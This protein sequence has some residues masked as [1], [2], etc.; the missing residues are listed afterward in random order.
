MPPPRPV[1]EPAAVVSSRSTG[2]NAGV[3]T[4]AQ[5][6]MTSAVD[7]LSTLKHR[8]RLSRRFDNEIRIEVMKPVSRLDRAEQSHARR[9]IGGNWR[10]RLVD[11][12]VSSVL[13]DYWDIF[14]D[15]MSSFL[16]GDDDLKSD[17]E[18]E[19]TFQVLL[20]A[21]PQY[22][23]RKQDRVKSKINRVVSQLLGSPE[24]RR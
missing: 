14:G 1:S 15:F 9:N 24:T 4:V 11:D 20:L 21:F 23:E 6:S 12:T 5:Q 2:Q 16:K 19:E 17:A 10:E 8:E 7:R 18:L 3:K 22:A 13:L